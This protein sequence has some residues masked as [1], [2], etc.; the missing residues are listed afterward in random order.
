[1]QNPPPPPPPPRRVQ[2]QPAVGPHLPFAGPQHVPGPRPRI[3][4]N[5]AAFWNFAPSLRYEMNRTIDRL[6]TLGAEYHSWRIL[7]TTPSFIP[8]QRQQN[9]ARERMAALIPQIR[10]AEEQLNEL[11]RG[12]ADPLGDRHNPGW[13]REDLPPRGSG[14]RKQRLP[15][16]SLRRR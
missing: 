10:A 5:Q 2:L 3:T 7:L 1:M 14:R 15:V 11:G 4:P 6:N 16:K 12:P 9:E 13:T 8:G